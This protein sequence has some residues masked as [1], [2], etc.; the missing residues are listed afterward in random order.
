M[1][2]GRRF[3]IFTQSKNF[4]T[5][6]TAWLSI[7][8]TAGLCLG[9]LNYFL[10]GGVSWAV[11]EHPVLF[12]TILILGV[13]EDSLLS[14]VILWYRSWDVRKPYSR[15]I[16][17]AKNLLCLT[18]GSSALFYHICYD[19]DSWYSKRYSFYIL[20]NYKISISYSTSLSFIFCWIWGRLFIASLFR[21]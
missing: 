11:T 19:I 4:R 5:R 3:Q 21:L 8:G 17:E 2:K 10:P 9:R 16:F 15:S 7:T 18:L 1:K 20:I 6:I 13:F 12:S 14:S